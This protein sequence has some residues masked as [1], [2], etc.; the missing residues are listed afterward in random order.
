MVTV[1][2]MVTVIYGFSVEIPWT[3]LWN[4]RRTR[5]QFLFYQNSK[6]ASEHLEAGFYVEFL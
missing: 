2:V 5:Q 3:V 1:T 4:V 6:P